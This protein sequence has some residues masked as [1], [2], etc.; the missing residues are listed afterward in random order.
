MTFGKEPPG[1][2]YASDPND[3]PNY[4]NAVALENQGK[5]TEAKELFEK[6]AQEFKSCG[7]EA[8]AEEARNK[9]NS[10]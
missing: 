1:Y 2:G 3:N 4:K 8:N 7:D 9:A 6:A 5:R 10:L